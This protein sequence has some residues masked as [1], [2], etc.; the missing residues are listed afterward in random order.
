MSALLTSSTSQTILNH[1]STTKVE[2][3]FRMS[4][5]FSLFC[6]F[7]YSLIGAFLVSISH[8]RC[9]WRRHPSEL[10]LV[11]VSTI[12][13]D[14]PV[15]T[16]VVMSSLIVVVIKTVGL[17]VGFEELDVDVGFHFDSR[18]LLSAFHVFDPFPCSGRPCRIPPP[19]QPHF[20]HFFLAPKRTVCGIWAMSTWSRWASWM[21]FPRSEKQNHSF[22]SYSSKP[23]VA[24]ATLSQSTSDPQW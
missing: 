1:V 12:E 14:G 16:V 21:R 17:P 8:S 18:E 3:L 20:S 6:T 15:Y 2:G 11:Q 24:L 19:C 9:D 5:L 7:C 10:V 4:C 13:V 23:A 22:A